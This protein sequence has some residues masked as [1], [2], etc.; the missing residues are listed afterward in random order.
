MSLIHLCI[1]FATATLVAADKAEPKAAAAK[2]SPRAELKSQVAPGAALK[3]EFPELTVDRKGA[4][5]TCN[6]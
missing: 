4:V 5:A 6:L 2:P 1:L 3:F